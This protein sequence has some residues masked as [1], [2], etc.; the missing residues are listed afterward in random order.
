MVQLPDNLDLA[1]P[2]FL[3]AW[4]LVRHTNKSIF[5]TGKAGTGKSTFLRYICERTKKKFVVLAPTGIAAVNVGG[6][7]IHSFFQM[8]LRPVPPDDPDYSVSHVLKKLKIKKEKLKLMQGI[9]L[10]IIDEVSMVRPDMIDFIDRVLRAVTRRRKEPFGGKQLLLVG[11]IFQLEPVVTPDTRTILSRFYPDFFFFN[12]IAYQKVPLV[13]I[14]LKKVYRQSDSDFIRL[15]DRIRVNRAT[16]DDLK[17]LNERLDNGLSDR[18]TYRTSDG[19]MVMTLASRR[20]LADAINARQMEL[21]PNPEKIFNGTIEGDFPERS[22]PTDLNL[23]V[24]KDEQIILLKNDKEKRWVNGTL[25]RVD[26]IED[27]NIR[28]RLE[29]GSVHALEREIWENIRY[30]FDEKE[31][32]VTEEIIGRFIQ[33]PIKAA[34]ALTV[35][36]SQ[37]LTFNRV[38]IELGQGAFSAGQTYVALSRCRSL[39]GLS[40]HSPISS[41]DV[42]VSQGAVRF[43]ECF[44]DKKQV[45]DALD[46]AKTRILYAEALDAFDN[47]DVEEAVAKMA[48]AFAISGNI[49]RPEVIRFI[50]RKLK[51]INRLE[52][53]LRQ[54]HDSMRS[55][56]IE[57]VEM[58]QECLMVKD[59]TD[60]ALSNFDKALRLDATLPDALCGR[61]EAL[62][63]LNRTV[64]AKSEL[65]RVSKN[66]SLSLLDISLLKG[67]LAELEDMPDEAL[68]SYSAALRISKKNPDIYDRLE[69]VYSQLGMDDMAEIHRNKARKLRTRGKNRSGEVSGQ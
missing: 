6:V 55:L 62:I 54:A 36:K 25:A 7:T 19:E 68:L 40:F 49:V 3:Q 23:A 15:L 65:D 43:A 10:L 20:D 60:A 14:E 12:A 24:K 64:E 67:E 66:K 31:N 9:D 44:N 2:E 45:T 16:P 4:N 46:E 38:N 56:A 22:L 1:N 52:D 48:E 17:R 21:N 18:M 58:G 33:F 35:H 61:I 50:T 26:A 8:P 57:Y 27:N 51:V 29:N 13:S 34:W 39:E 11:D 41:R 42:I 30:T 5:L 28:I 37:G 53:E 63:R 32:K 47:F 69:R 59:A